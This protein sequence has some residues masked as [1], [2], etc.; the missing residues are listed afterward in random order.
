MDNR[1]LILHKPAMLNLYPSHLRLFVWKSRVLYFGP[2]PPLSSHL[3][4][5]VALHVGVYRP[6][7]IRIA[8]RK[9]VTC[10]CAI[11]PPNTKHELDFSGGIHGKLFVERDST[12]FPYFQQRFSYQEPFG[13]FF[14]EEETL[15]SFRWIYEEDPEKAAVEA[16]LDRLMKDRGPLQYTIDPRIQSIIDLI[17]DEPDMNFSQEHLAT[18]VN[19]SP[20]RLL[21]L[22]KQHTSVS[23]R[24]FRM[25][26]RLRLAV[27]Q[28]NR[29]DNMTRVALDSGFADATHFSHCF[30]DTFGVNPAF[31]FRGIKR[32]EVIPK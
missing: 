24:R 12:D 22:F 18:L 10:R 21:H 29:T 9:P 4:G 31:V 28:F 2:S 30:R 1:S 15:N 16:C 19:L 25:W 7:R 17:R 13:S 14:Q 8:N 23:Y 27:E 3:Y 32:F 5:T 26:K 6:F 20:S 11:V